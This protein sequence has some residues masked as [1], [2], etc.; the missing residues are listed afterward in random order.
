MKY[1]LEYTVKA[2]D[3]GMTVRGVARRRLGVSQRL[4]RKI[5]NAGAGDG[6]S[7]LCG[8]V[9]INGRPARFVDRVGEG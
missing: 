1:D 9:F 3:V 2:T 4:M 5:A 6:D 8:G 7:A